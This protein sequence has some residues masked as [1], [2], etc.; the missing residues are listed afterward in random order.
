MDAESAILIVLALVCIIYC[1]VLELLHDRYVPDWIWL[2]VVIGEAFV[3]GALALMERY[4]V[5]ITAVRVLYANGAAGAPII[6]WQLYQVVRR[7]QERHSEP[8]PRR[9]PTPRSD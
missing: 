1:I 2:T 9:A 5:D 8:T 7:K 4:D 3:I 6:L